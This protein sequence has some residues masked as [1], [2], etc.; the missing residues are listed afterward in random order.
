LFFWLSCFWSLTKQIK[1]IFVNFLNIA[2]EK[3]FFFCGFLQNNRN[4]IFLQTIIVFRDWKTSRKFT[5]T[6]VYPVWSWL[7]PSQ[8]SMSSKQSA[9]RTS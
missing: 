8:D 7:P 2:E 4:L 9:S 6:R 5:G 1:I 3:N